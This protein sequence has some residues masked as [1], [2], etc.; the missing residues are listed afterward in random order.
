M[1]ND[2]IIFIYCKYYK[3]NVFSWLK[4][5]EFVHGQSIFKAF[6]SLRLIAFESSVAQQQGESRVITSHKKPLDPKWVR[7][8]MA[9]SVQLRY[10]RHVT[11]SLK[12]HNRRKEQIKAQLDRYLSQGKVNNFFPPQYRLLTWKIHTGNHASVSTDFIYFLKS[13]K[14]NSSVTYYYEI[15]MFYKIT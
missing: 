15:P 1:C 7:T 4:C 2:F 14:R 8:E 6:P 10:L 13:S 5:P 11:W 12:A 3:W 9:Y